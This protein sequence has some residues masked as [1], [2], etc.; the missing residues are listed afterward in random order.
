MPRRFWGP[1]T[2]RLVWSFGLALLAA[3]VCLA[4]VVAVAIWGMIKPRPFAGLAADEI[5]NYTSRRFLGEPDLWRIQ[6]RSL[7]SLEAAVRRTEEQGDAVADAISI[8][9]Y[10]F[11]GGLGFSLI[12]LGT[13]IL[14]LIR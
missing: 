11:L 3:V 7:R 2:A 14:E 12:L 4:A 1:P 10:A 5:T 6:L 8:A 9:I 13:L